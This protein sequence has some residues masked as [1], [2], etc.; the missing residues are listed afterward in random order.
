[1][2][3]SIGKELGRILAQK[4]PN[5]KA[6]TVSPN[7]GK[8]VRDIKA[9]K[10]EY[11]LDKTGIVHT[12]VGKANF[13][14]QRSSPKTSAR[15]STRSSREAV[16]GE[17]HVPAFD[18]ADLDDGPGRQG[19][20]DPREADRDH[21]LTAD[22]E[23]REAGRNALRLFSFMVTERTPVIAQRQMLCMVVIGL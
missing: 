19:R 14:E 16:G 17:G 2:M 23:A 20:S 18:H 6:G 22:A 11:R 13:E 7:I 10:V 15:C 1:M 9:G 3:P 5:P 4:M 21:G 8:A 12:I